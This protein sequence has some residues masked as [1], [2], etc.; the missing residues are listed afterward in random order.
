MAHILLE[1]G[2]PCRLCRL[3]AAAPRGELLTRRR[4]SCRKTASLE[5]LSRAKYD[6]SIAIE[7]FRDAFGVTHEAA[8]LRFT[9]LA[10]EQLGITLHFLRVTGEGAVVRAYENERKGG[11][12]NRTALRRVKK[13][14]ATS[15]W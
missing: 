10:T 15:W 9:N 4:A 11:P 5:F 2:A 14:S 8:A 1:H 7:D 12:A 3:L 6:R 13:R